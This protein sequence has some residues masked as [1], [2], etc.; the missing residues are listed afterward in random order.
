[1]VKTRTLGLSQALE[2]IERASVAGDSADMLTGQHRHAVA[3]VSARDVIMRCI[4][5]MFDLNITRLS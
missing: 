4:C 1:M 5:R 3:V 2:E